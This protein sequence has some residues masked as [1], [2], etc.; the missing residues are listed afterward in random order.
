MYFV[1]NF[2]KRLSKKKLLST[3]VISLIIFILFLSLILL[4]YLK[5]LKKEFLR[6]ISFSIERKIGHKVF[7]DDMYFVSFKEINLKDI[8][9]SNPE[10]FSKGNLLRV[11]KI[12]MRIRPKEL[13]K[14]KVVFDYI[15]IVEPQLNI[16]RDKKG[17]IN[18]S[19]RLL[20]LFKKKP[21]QKYKFNKLV[22]E[23]GNFNLITED[24]YEFKEVKMVIDNIS[25]AYDNKVILN[26]NFK[27]LRG[28][29]DFTGWFIYKEDP[30]K[31]NLAIKTT[32][33]DFSD[34]KLLSNIN[35][36]S[37]LD[38]ISIY[39]EISNDKKIYIKNNL[40]VSS[41]S[42]YK[43]YFFNT[44]F[45][46]LSS[47]INLKF[48][49]KSI[50][51]ID[52]EAF[53]NIKGIFVKDKKR[54]LFDNAN[55]N[56]NV[57]LKSDKFDFKIFGNLKKIGFDIFGKLDIFGNK[58]FRLNLEIALP[59]IKA[60]DFRESLWNIFP[61]S[62]LYANLQGLIS[63][64]SYILYSPDIFSIKG[65]VSLKDFVI[66]GENKEYFIG[67][68]NGSF[69]VV[70]SRV[71][72]TKCGDLSK[73]R[74]NDFKYSSDMDE[75]SY[76]LDIDKI[77]YG[78]RIFEKINI[79]SNFDDNRIKI[80]NLNSNVYNGLVKGSGY[81]EIS[82]GLNYKIDFSLDGLSLSK[83]CDEITP[84]KGYIS[85]KVRGYGMIK[86]EGLGLSKIK[87]IANFNA[88]KTESEK[89]KISKE[90]LRK[91]G[92]PSIGTYLRDRV[93]D[94]G[95][96]N[97]YIQDGFII[98]KDF[99]ISNRNFFGMKDLSIKVAPLS[100]RISIEHLMWSI[101]EAAKRVKKQ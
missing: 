66:E 93:F 12:S 6:K 8:L 68:L 16:M 1:E 47:K 25:S 77:D 54:I 20:E 41:T 82:N 86:G 74:K 33:I 43:K 45:I 7:I 95:I 32:Q 38:E 29:I 30:K 92:G 46:K 97:L 31:F 83:L 39:A 81:L 9:I 64:K 61:D 11:K 91:V 13:L 73:F 101:S 59:Y 53:I 42:F 65:V 85:G 21:E 23:D 75:R 80:S 57:F 96:M 90:F 55:F 78:F 24:K 3:V 98:F 71:D 67:L 63:A 37:S 19:E 18:V 99:E 22:I 69:P 84:I 17:N 4:F 44:D 48:T 50:R 10:H 27:F 34:I 26:G 49:N 89:M 62:L 52:G 15:R 72:S 51:I 56:G 5:D 87:G 28:I 2:Y 88:Y 36:H 60:S 14:S 94:T 100:N 58:K 35:L 76:A 70:Y 79:V 40:S